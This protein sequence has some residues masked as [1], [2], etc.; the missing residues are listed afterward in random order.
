MPTISV[1]A[2]EG[3]H[4]FGEPAAQLK[5]IERLLAA[6]KG[7]ALAL[8]PECAITG[9]VSHQLKFEL[10][11]FAEPLEGPTAKRISKLAREHRVAI[12]APLIE[13]DGDRAFNAFVVF[14][15]KGERV[16]HYRKR[17]PW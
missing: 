7:A 11:R 17:N 5:V 14:D 6:A 9:Y 16:A 12:A 3:P 10:R 4:R 1:A 15:Q 2:L 13:L 8:L